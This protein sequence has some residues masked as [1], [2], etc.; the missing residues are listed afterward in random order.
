MRPLM[1]YQ[2]KIDKFF[3]RSGCGG[4][5]GNAYVTGQSS[6]RYFNNVVHHIKKK[7]E[8]ILTSLKLWSLYV[9]RSKRVEK[10]RMNELEEFS[11][12]IFCP[13]LSIAI[14]S[15]ENVSTEN[16]LGNVEDFRF[17][18]FSFS[19]WVLEYWRLVYGLGARKTRST[20]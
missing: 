4:L 18:I 15:T 7:K 10:A 20:T 17:F 19:Y 16:P 1:Y 3:S 5:I 11:F 2:S 13:L 14:Y 9:V 12:F 6:I 8:N